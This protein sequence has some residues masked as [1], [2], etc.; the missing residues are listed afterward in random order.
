MKSL[1]LLGQPPGSEPHGLPLLRLGFRPF[2][3]LAAVAG[4]V[5]M[6]LWWAAF[7]GHLSPA[8][9]L[10]PVLWHAHEMLFGLVAAVV[11]GFVFTAGK[12]WTGLATPRGGHLLFFAALWVAGRLAALLAPY[13]VFFLIDLVFLPLAAATFADLVLRSN[14]SRNLIVVVILALLGAANLWF[15]LGASGAL[16]LN[17]LAA[18]HG[19][20]AVLVMLETLIAG[21]VVPFFARSVTPG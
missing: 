12:T 8:S 21:R 14:N 5:L 6:P 1:P 4:V 18:L 19:G 10:S 13:P 3:L 9:G 17:P 2:Y 7:T 16:D 20:L 11:V 15:H